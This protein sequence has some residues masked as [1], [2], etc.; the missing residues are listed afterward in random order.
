MDR[1]VNMAV[2]TNAPPEIKIASKLTFLGK[3][4][5][6]DV[7]DALR[8]AGLNPNIKADGLFAQER[9]YRDFPQKDYYPNLQPV[10]A[11]QNIEAMVN[12]E[13]Q[14]IA[15]IGRQLKAGL[16]LYTTNEAAARAM[17]NSV[18]GEITWGDRNIPAP[19]RTPDGSLDTRD[20]WQWVGKKV[21]TL[22]TTMPENGKFFLPLRNALAADCA[23]ELQSPRPITVHTNRDTLLGFGN[24]AD[25]PGMENIVHLPQLPA[26]FNA[27]AQA[28]AEQGRLENM[29]GQ[30]QG[31]NSVSDVARSLDIAVQAIDNNDINTARQAINDAKT[32]NPRYAQW[33]DTALNEGRNSLRIK[34]DTVHEILKTPP[35]QQSNAALQSLV[36][37]DLLRIVE[38]QRRGDPLSPAELTFSGVVCQYIKDFHTMKTFHNQPLDVQKNNIRRMI[39]AA[40]RTRPQINQAEIDQLMNGIN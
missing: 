5:D 36:S 39:R 27:E 14:R 23:A 18:V 10:K 38:T 8:A 3:R 22:E 9:G 13:E 25:I 37:P 35:G 19:V 12:W 40:A 4:S 21:S 15:R 29:R 11:P 28:G 24:G 32:N 30:F 20:Y 17:V 1:Q 26:A 31:A 16:T 33:L 2:G 6:R 7:K 34:L